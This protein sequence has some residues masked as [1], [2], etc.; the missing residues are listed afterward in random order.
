MVDG[1]YD[2]QQV[3]SSHQDCTTMGKVIDDEG[4]EKLDNEGNVDVEKV[5]FGS[6]DD[7]MFV[8]DDGSNGVYIPTVS[9][10]NLISK[11]NVSYGK[12]ANKLV[13]LID[14][15]LINIPTDALGNEFVIFDEELINDGRISA[16]A[17]RIGKPLIMDA[18]TT[19]MCTQNV[20][21]IGYARVLIKV[22]AKKV[23]YDWTP[24]VCFE[25]DVFGH[26]VLGCHKNHNGEILNENGNAQVSDQKQDEFTEVTYKKKVSRQNPNKSKNS[27]AKKQNTNNGGGLKSFK[28]VFQPKTSSNNVNESSEGSKSNSTPETNN[29]NDALKGSEN[30]NV[31]TL[32]KGIGKRDKQGITTHQDN[33]SANKYFVLENLNEEDEVCE[34]A[35]LNKG[36]QVESRKQNDYS[37]EEIEDVYS[38]EDGMAGEMNEK[39]LRGLDGMSSST[40]QDEVIN[41]IATEKLNVCV[42]LETHLKSIVLDKIVEDRWKFDV[43]GLHMYNLVKKMKSLKHPLNNLNWSNSN[44]VEKVKVLKDDL[45]KIQTEIY[46]D[47]YD[48]NLRDKGRVVLEKYLEA[49]KDEEKLL[50]QKCKIKWLSYGDKNNSFFHKM[51]KGRGLNAPVSSID[52]CKDLFI[53][54]LSPY[55]SI[56]MVKPITDN[57]IKKAMFN[58]TDNKAPGPDGFLAKFFKAAWHIVGSDVCSAVK[59]IFSSGKLLGELNGTIISLI[60][61][62]TTPMLVT[63]F[64]P[65]ACCNV[66]Y[67]CISKVITER[68]KG[69]L[70]KLINKNQS[71]FIPGR[72]IQDNILLAQDLMQGYNRFGGLKRV[73][74]KTDI[75]KAYDTGSWDFMEQ[76]LK[77][78]DFHEKM[79][80]WV[81]SIVFFGSIKEDDKQKLLSVLPFIKGN[82]PVRYLGVPLIS[83]RLGIKDF[84]PKIMINDIN[85]IM[86]NFLWSQSDDSKGKAKVA[87]KDMCKPENQ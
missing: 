19:S 75:Q 13:N 46:T 21:R 15:K 6:V 18:S 47:P 37:N 39:D 79:R 28:S 16:L 26:N 58:I 43:G 67:K 82:L 42:I 20:E 40:K 41:L 53:T 85:R 45:K 2:S 69:C 30:M 1:N 59:E 17:S 25:C 34:M 72:L 73:A 56:Q 35:G 51:I 66:V 83:K 49:V 61:K 78:F 38:M 48:K 54:K 44:L 64:R 36:D 33:R 3:A 62:L 81:M 76:L 71:A 14:N 4:G 63:D 77:H 24:S 70:D 80:N 29:L 87:W 12:A 22:S 60:P 31:N 23:M 11:T 8:G 27:W 10:S 68:L 74:F 50:Y 32:K 84:L 5:L 55:E 65:I 52:T 9:K 57:E 7:I 86:K